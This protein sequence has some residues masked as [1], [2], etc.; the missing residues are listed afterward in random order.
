MQ[1][2]INDLNLNIESKKSIKVVTDVNVN[3]YDQV[4]RL[5]EENRELKKKV[6]M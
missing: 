1:T 2:E 5:T 3:L 6:T 4:K